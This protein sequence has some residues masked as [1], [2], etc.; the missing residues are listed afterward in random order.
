MTSTDSH[1]LFANSLVQ[2]MIT[3]AVAIVAQVIL[4]EVTYRLVARIVKRHKHTS[5]Q[6]EL[7]REETLSNV[8]KTVIAVAIWLTVIIVVLSEIG[9]NVA[10]LLTGAG[11]VGILVGFGAQNAIKDYLAGLFIIIENQYRFG[12]IVTLY[13]GGALVSGVVEDISLRTTR[14]RDLDGNLHI[15]QNGSGGPVTNHSFTYANVNID[16]ALSYDSDI[17]EVR[18]I[19]NEIGDQQSKEDVWSSQI[20]EP[21][22]FL[23]LDSFTERAV[24]VKAVGKVKPAKQ[25]GIAGDYRLRLKKAFD[26]HGVTMPFPQVVVHQAKKSS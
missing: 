2:I 6:E 10:A 15:V 8:F 25:W 17:D 26:K 18:K 22:Q 14:L 1:G 24:I 16:I 7:Q 19:I 23:R 21:I 4:R 3:V 11:I 13:A 20:I 12:D 9:I 5:H